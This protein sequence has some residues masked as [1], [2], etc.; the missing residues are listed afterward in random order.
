MTYDRVEQMQKL[1][2]SYLKRNQ[3]VITNQKNRYPFFKN[4]HNCRFSPTEFEIIPIKG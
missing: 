1:F 2:K 4:R 3:F